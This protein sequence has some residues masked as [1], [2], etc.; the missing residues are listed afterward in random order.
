MNKPASLG[1]TNPLNDQFGAHPRLGAG[2][3]WDAGALR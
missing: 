1:W 3:K 2:V